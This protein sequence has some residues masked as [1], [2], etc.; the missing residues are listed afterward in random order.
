MALAPVLQIRRILMLHSAE[1]V[2]VG[3]FA[4][5]LP[6]FMLW[7][8]YGL[9]AANP[10]IYV[11]NSIATIVNAATIVVAL[12]YRTTTAAAASPRV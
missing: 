6:G 10:V 9:A 7:V 8:A 3:L 4:V 5:L 1:D 11:P 2:S 12:K